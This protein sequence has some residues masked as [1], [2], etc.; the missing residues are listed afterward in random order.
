MDDLEPPIPGT[1]MG[2]RH[3]VVVKQI[4]GEQP[5]ERL[6]R[7]DLEGADLDDRP[8]IRDRALLA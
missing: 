8:G 2:R 5:G 7:L 6:A 3:V 4:E 1:G